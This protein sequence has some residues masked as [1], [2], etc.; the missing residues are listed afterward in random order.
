MVTVVRTYG[1]RRRCTLRDAAVADP[2]DIA[3]KVSEVFRVLAVSV[4][5]LREV[6]YGEA[7]INPRKLA[8]ELV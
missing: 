1:D 4:K 6:R 8:N 3:Q 7:I 2:G 5:Q